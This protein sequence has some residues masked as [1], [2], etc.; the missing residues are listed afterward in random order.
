MTV[1]DYQKIIDDYEKKFGKRFF[2][3]YEG[4]F[5]LIH[6]T[7]P[8]MQCLF[9]QAQLL[10]DNGEKEKAIEQYKYMLRLNPNDNQGVRDSLLPNLLELNRLD[11]AEELYLKYEDDITANWKFGKLLL[12]IKTNASF[13]EIEMQYKEC[14]KYNPY[15]VPYLM[16]K[17]KLPRRM[18]PFYGIG[19]KNEAVFYVVLSADA[20]HS[21]K[22]SMKVLKRLSKK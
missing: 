7:R 2:E 6:E 19:D 9:D 15:V 13:N 22:K 8:Y 21:D 5:W 3:E 10:W 4:E 1:E 14:V 11:E 12:D 17:K 18:P 16:G 20:W